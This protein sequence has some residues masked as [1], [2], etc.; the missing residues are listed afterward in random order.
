MSTSE[1]S[2]T[3]LIHVPYFD[4]RM[5]NQLEEVKAKGI[6]SYTD[7][8]DQEEV[9]TF[10]HYFFENTI[11]KN[12]TEERKQYVY[13]SKG[14]SRSV[15][16]AK[17]IWF[18]IGR[19]DV[20]PFADEE[21]AILKRFAKVFEQSYTRFLD[22]QKAE[23]Q[24]REA[25]IEAALERVRS[26][27]MAMHQSV[28]L[29]E[30]AVVVFD[31]LKKLG[32]SIIRTWLNIFNSELQIS[33]VWITSLFEANPYPHKVVLPLNKDSKI[34]ELTRQW[35]KGAEYLEYSFMGDEAIQYNRTLRELTGD[36]TLIPDKI[37]NEFPSYYLFEGCHKYGTVGVSSFEPISK[38]IGEIVKRFAKVLEQTYA[39]FLDLQKAERQANEAQIEAGLERVRSRAM[40]MQTSEE[41]NSL[42]GTVFTELTRLDLALTRCVI[43][44]IDKETNGATWWMANSEDANNPG[45]F[46][47]KYHEHLPYLTLL[48]EWKKQNVKYVYDLHGQIKKDW[49]D[50][51]FSETELVHLP[52]LV[53]DGMRAPDRI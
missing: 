42:I 18:T 51:L 37:L 22:L 14:F 6:G 49:D 11:A 28:E 3:A 30:V 21:N 26:R 41:L 23:A 46:Y 5:F 36:N 52:K 19:Y 8:Y 17:D 29:S 9:N 13:D 27:S 4:H 15:F 25:Q 16:L 53:Q 20:I 10:F 39:R 47:I 34:I 24:A 35:K 38:D 32:L 7:F 1:Q 33:E 43:W 31:Q 12:A 50:F 44:I 48:N 45:G 40:A 2:Y